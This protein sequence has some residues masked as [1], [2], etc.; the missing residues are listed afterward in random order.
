MRDKLQKEFGYL[1]KSTN[2]IDSFNE[3]FKQ[4]KKL[5]FTKLCTPLEEVQSMQEALI[6]L[7]SSTGGLKEQLR[8]KE[9]QFLKF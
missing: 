4:L 1:S 2:E 8:I 3:Q 5:W 6:K 7:K 9:D